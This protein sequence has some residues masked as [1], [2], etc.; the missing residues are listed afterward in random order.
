MFI[1]ENI[2]EKCNKDVESF[3]G[4]EKIQPQTTNTKRETTKRTRYYLKVGTSF[5]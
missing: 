1:V 3:E 2:P 5:F 4:A